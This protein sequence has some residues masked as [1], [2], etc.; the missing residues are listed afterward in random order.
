MTDH[1]Y[2][3]V[4]YTDNQGINHTKSVTAPDP[5]SAIEA[6]ND[7]DE[8]KEKVTVRKCLP[9]QQDDKELPT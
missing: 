9:T 8:L 3:I 1:K 4:T 5:F 7:S 2:Y 6:L